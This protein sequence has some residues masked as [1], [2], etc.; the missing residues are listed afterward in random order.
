[1]EN[2]SEFNTVIFKKVLF[3]LG[4]VALALII[5]VHPFIDENSVSINGE[6]IGDIFWARALVICFI[7]LM[8]LF[9]SVC[10]EFSI[11]FNKRWRS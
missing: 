11:R 10:I 1:M 8:W 9:F 5:I 3:R 2:Q 7:L 4:I 6:P